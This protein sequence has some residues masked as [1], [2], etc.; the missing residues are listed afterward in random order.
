MQIVE[1]GVASAL[2]IGAL[3]RSDDPI[4]KDLCA[5]A[6]FNLTQH[7]PARL[8]LLQDGVLWAVVKLGTEALLADGQQPEDVLHAVE[9]EF[10]KPSDAPEVG[11][12]KR[13]P[14][15]PP[16]GAGLKLG[17]TSNQE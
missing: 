13:S 16:R 15:R 4:T 9:Q 3:F 17:A 11:V 6:L 1:S 10:N 7:T 2:T 5:S 12:E 8:A 14:G